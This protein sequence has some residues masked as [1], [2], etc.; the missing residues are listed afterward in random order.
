[1]FVIYQ[2]MTHFFSPSDDAG[3]RRGG[4]QLWV[5]FSYDPLLFSFKRAQSIRE[6]T[7]QSMS[8][9]RVHAPVAYH[10]IAPNQ[11]VHRSSTH[12]TSV[13]IIAAPFLVSPPLTTTLRSRHEH[14][15]YVKELVWGVSIFPHGPHA[16]PRINVQ[17]AIQL[18]CDGCHLIRFAHCDGQGWPSVS[19]RPRVCPGSMILSLPHDISAFRCIENTAIW[20]QHLAC[21]DPHLRGILWM[22]WVFRGYSRRMPRTL[23][24][25]RSAGASCHGSTATFRSGEMEKCKLIH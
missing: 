8:P 12:F 5:V 17:P 4:T 7:T 25:H 6:I 22:L 23:S 1:M 14:G 2:S 3:R 18:F 9:E 20:A 13:I 16:D 21:K 11:F 10:T 19:K 24:P 15:N